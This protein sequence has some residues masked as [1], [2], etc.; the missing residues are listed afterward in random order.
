MALR[1]TGTSLQPQQTTSATSPA[2]SAAPALCAQART[3]L[4]RGDL[5]G[6][7]GLFGGAAA[8]EDPHRRYEAQLALLDVG[9]ATS[10]SCS[11][12]NAVRI[13]LAVAEATLAM[14]EAT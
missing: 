5:A 4:M 2:V 7:G 11:D 8:M 1:L 13:F 10:R 9:L 14:L 6:Y 3:S 12:A